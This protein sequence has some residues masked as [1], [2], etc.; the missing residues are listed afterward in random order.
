MC[1]EGLKGRRAPSSWGHTDRA[2]RILGSKNGE[3]GE[4]GG[5][6]LTTRVRS[7]EDNDHVFF[8]FICL[9]PSSH[10]QAT[11]P[12]AGLSDEGSG[13]RVAELERERTRVCAEVQ[14]QTEAER[15]KSSQVLGSQTQ[16]IQLLT[17]GGKKV[18]A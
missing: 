12:R 4:E 3:G 5:R 16:N 18:T 7:L 17:T 1:H 9:H 13:A 2:H 11:H 15:R 10:G 14:G 8:V 6:A